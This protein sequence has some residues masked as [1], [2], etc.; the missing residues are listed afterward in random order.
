MAVMRRLLVSRTLWAL[1]ALAFLSSL[2]SLA[3]RGLAKDPRFLA[4]PVLEGRGPAW[5]GDE[6]LRP[7]LANLEALGPVN[8]FDPRFEARVRAAVEAFPGVAAVGAVRRLWPDRY[9]VDFAFERPLVVVFQEGRGTPVT[10]GG[11]VLPAFPYA[12]ASRGLFTVTGVDSSAPPDGARWR[13]PLLRAGID[14]LQQ[15]APYLPELGALGLDR[16]DVSTAD[17]PRR[18]VV[19]YGEDGTAVRWGRPRSVG[20]NA[21]EQKALF[22]RAAA[23]RVSRVRG[24]E[25]DV[26]YDDLYVRE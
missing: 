10:A 25:I 7:V 8:L 15:I 26:R 6:L 16:I 20:E 19:F 23:A 13:S 11:R 4:R 14:A 18:G 17:D 2:L 3:R 24:V 5:G 12:R 22:L 1:V 21:V 9:A